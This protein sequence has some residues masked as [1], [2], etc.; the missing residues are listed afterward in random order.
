MPTEAPRRG[1]PPATVDLA[2]LPIVARVLRPHLES[3]D[4]RTMTGLPAATLSEFL[5]G[6]LPNPGFNTL[7]QLIAGIRPLDKD[8]GWG[9]FGRQLAAA[10][11]LR[12]KEAIAKVRANAPRKK[13][14]FD[15]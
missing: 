8:G 11:E 9:W 12:T 3:A 14:P 10:N 6:H 2:S 5:N 7:R 13:S 1:R 4:A 15:R